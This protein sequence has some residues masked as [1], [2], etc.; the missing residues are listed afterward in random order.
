MIDQDHIKHD[1]K[2][3]PYE[4]EKWENPQEVS[5]LEDCRFAMRYTVPVY[6]AIKNAESDPS[7]V[8]YSTEDSG[9]D[10]TCYDVVAKMVKDGEIR[11]GDTVEMLTWN[12]GLDFVFDNAYEQQIIIDPVNATNPKWAI[13]TMGEREVPG[14]IDIVV[15]VVGIG[16]EE[17][18]D[19]AQPCFVLD[20]RPD[21]GD[22][23]GFRE[24]VQT[25]YNEY[26]NGM[27]AKNE[28]VI[29]C[30]VRVSMDDVLEEHDYVDSLFPPE[31]DEDDAPSLSSPAAPAR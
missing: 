18:P 25:V 9:A 17:D 5:L 7:F 3:I 12:I 23:E 6:A 21:Y 8:I 20:S 16:S 24:V 31:D 30:R 4:S 14:E 2:V 13:N 27:F 15:A 22:G 29:I 19:G 1:P 10:S 26:G 11:D 28:E